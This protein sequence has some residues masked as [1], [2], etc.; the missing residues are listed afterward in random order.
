[1]KTIRVPFVLFLLVCVVAF[2]GCA[3]VNPPGA[4]TQPA[5]S[6][7]EQQIALAE[8]V[9][10]GAE[11]A[12]SVAKL[13]PQQRADV[14]LLVKESRKALTQLEA[15]ARA[16][17]VQDATTISYTAGQLLKDYLDYRATH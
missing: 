8:N 14:A 3:L 7:V 15:D 16:G 10:T 11:L 1:M 17:K 2:A 9:F 12:I 4:T 13:N 5:L 6:P